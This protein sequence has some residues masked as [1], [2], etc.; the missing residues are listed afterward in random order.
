M[1]RT[2]AGIWVSTDA[3]LPNK[4]FR[5]A[6]EKNIMDKFSDYDE[7]YPEVT[8]NNSRIDF[9]L[10]NGSLSCYLE[11]KSVTLVLKRTGL[12]PDAPTVRGRKHVVELTKLAEHGIKSSVVFI[13]QRPDAD[14]VSPNKRT[15]PEFFNALK[16]TALRGV[17]LIAYRCIT[18]QGII[19]VEKEIPVEL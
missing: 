7:M 14:I 16:I 1:I 15:D 11:I 17:D 10:K 5:E 9:L 19:K 4:L 3:R 12:F 6:F 8:V 2:N 13:V 18:S